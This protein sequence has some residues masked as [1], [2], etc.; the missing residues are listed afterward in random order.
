MEATKEMREHLGK[1][2]TSDKR[3]L[4]DESAFMLALLILEDRSEAAK[5]RKCAVT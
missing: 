4:E 3:L 5:R 2:R 1:E